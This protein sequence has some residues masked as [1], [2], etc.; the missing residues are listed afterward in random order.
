MAKPPKIPPSQLEPAVSEGDA[1]KAAEEQ[2]RK[3]R[4]YFRRELETSVRFTFENEQ[5]ECLS[6]TIG[7]GGMY[8][9]TLLPPPVG[10]KISVKFCLPNDP[11][12]ISAVAK[13]VHCLPYAAGD[14]PAGFGLQFL[15]ISESD[16]LRITTYVE[17]E[18]V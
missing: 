10:S 4:R 3:Q 17:T 7:A 18:I 8:I 9:Q 5:R 16:R 1:K 2:Q 12:P 11:Q 14:L 13:V 15:N 6:T